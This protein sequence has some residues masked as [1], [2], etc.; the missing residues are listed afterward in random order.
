MVATAAVS[1][2]Q[3]SVFA[4][5]YAA[6]LAD[7]CGDKLALVK[8]LDQ[9]WQ[10]GQLSNQEHTPALAVASPGLPPQLRLVP[11][12]QVGMRK[13][14][15][16]DGRAAL[17]HAIAHIEFNAINLALD[18]VYRFRGLPQ[19]YYSDWLRVAREE[20]YH[21]SLL[22]EHLRSYGYGYGDFVAHNGL[23]D[24]ASASDDDV[25]V[26]MALVPRLMEARGLDVT[27]GLQAKLRQAGDHAVVAILDIILRDEI[28]HV[29]IGNRWYAWCCAE[30]GVEPLT[31]F[32]RLLNER[33]T[34]GLRPPFNWVARLEAGFSEAERAAIEGM[35]GN[36]RSA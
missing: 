5:A 15:D 28:G 30:R 4:R 16:A 32:L 6:L 2:S 29:A 7:D 23:W 11:P 10:A 36:G 22:N 18:A 14:A 3:P 1:I 26:R 9:D 20:A 19:D 35:L 12:R 31:T 8:A 24:M 21:F 34:P 17:I 33:K 13:L 27:P 25:L